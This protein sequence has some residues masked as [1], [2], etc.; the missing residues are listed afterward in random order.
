MVATKRH[1]APRH[2]AVR[3]VA[4]FDLGTFSGLILVA[5][6]HRGKIEAMREEAHTVDLFRESG[7]TRRIGSAAL[8]R[9]GGVLARLDAL[10][11][12]LGCERGVVICTEAIRSAN[13]RD[14]VVA[15][16]ARQTRFPIRVVSQRREALLAASGALIGLPISKRPSSVIDVGGGSTEIMFPRGER[17][18]SFRGVRCGAARATRE[19]FADGRPAE[20]TVCE[21]GG[22]VF[23]SLRLPHALRGHRIVGVG[24]TITTLA[25]IELRLRSYS[26]ERI[27]GV[28][29]SVG[30]IEQLARLLLGKSEP[31]IAGLIP[32]DP[33]RAR[34]LTAG[35]FLWAG[36][37][38]RVGAQEVTVS[39]H[40]LRWGAAA[41]LLESNPS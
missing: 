15:A 27:H 14:S 23:R 38:N 24:G 28:R 35:T 26:A 40:G 1:H 17:G 22:Q 18:W 8:S 16:L 3:P 34:V 7:S 9:A 5:R 13:N 33:A 10:A 21:R 12:E 37:L 31:G 2:N 29:L 11:A 19:W 41:R 30:R 36:V 32:Y 39:V 20:E 4:V 25:A 6:K